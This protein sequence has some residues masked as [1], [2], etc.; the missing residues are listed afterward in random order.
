MKKLITILLV[1]NA[2]FTNAQE[3]YFTEIKLNPEFVDLRIQDLYQD[4][5]SMVWVGTQRG[6]IRHNGIKDRIYKGSDGADISITAIFRDKQDV[7][8]CGSEDG[9]LYILQSEKQFD[10]LY[11]KKRLGNKINNILQDKH[12]NIWIATYGSGLYCFVDGNVRSINTKGGLASDEIYD[13]AIINDNKIALATDRGLNIVSKVG[14][15]YSVDFYN[16]R[17][18]FTDDILTDVLGNGGDTLFIGTNTGEV[19]LFDLSL[20]KAS[21]IAS[22]GSNINRIQRTIQDEI[23]IATDNGI[24]VHD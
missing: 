7:V 16:E 3:P 21:T 1:A 12:G 4:N 13:I 6:L 18:G 15:T 23:F 22:P 20:K 11:F 8:W 14:E 9:V 17:N 2:L 5:N 19:L 10:H 24:F